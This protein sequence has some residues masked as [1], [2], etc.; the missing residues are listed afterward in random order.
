MTILQQFYYVVLATYYSDLFI[1]YESWPSLG[2]FGE[3]IEIGNYL[4][5]STK[6]NFKFIKLITVYK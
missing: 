6:I 3:K 1:F 5:S 2:A 4:V